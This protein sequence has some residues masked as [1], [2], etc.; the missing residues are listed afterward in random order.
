MDKSNELWLVSNSASGSNTPAALRELESVCESGSARFAKRTAFPQED[1]PTRDELDAAGIETVAVYAGD[2]TVNAVIGALD[3]W[4]GAVLV[5]PGGTMNLLSVRLHGDTEAREILQRHCAGATRRF[6]P[7]IMRCS[8]GTALAGLL[9][10]PGTAW[11]SVREAMRDTALGELI[12]SAG[13]AIDKTANAPG[14]LFTRPKL[15]REDAYPLVELTPGA[16]GIQFD[17]YYAEDVIDMAKQS[18]ALLRRSFREGPHDRLGLLEEAELSSS[19]G[20]PLELLLDGEPAK[21]LP[22]ET[23]AV[24]PCGVDLWVSENGG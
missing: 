16:F 11:A 22:Q 13:E 10:G 24:E 18:W 14:V 21:G 4:S 12:E 17:G 8:A 6:R 20:S 2:G 19:D 3:G 15:G 7:Q 9:V 5:M 1:L 23:F